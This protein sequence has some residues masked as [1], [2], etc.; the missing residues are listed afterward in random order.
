VKDVQFAR[1]RATFIS[2]SRKKVTARV[3]HDFLT[4]GAL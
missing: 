1:G 2:T 3:R 4:T